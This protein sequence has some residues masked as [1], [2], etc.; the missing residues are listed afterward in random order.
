MT[1]RSPGPDGRHTASSV[2]RRLDGEDLVDAHASLLEGERAPDEV[3]PPDAPDLLADH[4]D[5]AVP[6]GLERV[7]P[8]VHGP[9]VVLAHRMDVAD[10]ES[11]LLD[12][13]DG[14]A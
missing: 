9:H 2:G 3:E 11:C 13:V 7:V 4:G 1:R 12:E 10:L 6:V 8:G 5:D 14:L